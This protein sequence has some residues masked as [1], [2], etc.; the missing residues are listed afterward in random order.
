MK[1]RLVKELSKK[2]TVESKDPSITI[3]EFL[4]KNDFNSAIEEAGAICK[5][6]F[7]SSISTDL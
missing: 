5:A 7:S 6:Y 3:R 2:M 1:N 4:E